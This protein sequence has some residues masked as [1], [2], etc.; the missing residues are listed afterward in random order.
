MTHRRR[1]YVCINILSRIVTQ[2]SD[3]VIIST[4][5]GDEK[6]KNSGS[7]HFYTQHENN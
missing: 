3:K 2:S 1:P 6:G 7:V 4:L 5:H